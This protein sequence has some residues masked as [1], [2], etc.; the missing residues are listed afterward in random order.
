MPKVKIP[1][2]DW[3]KIRFRIGIYLLFINIP[4]G[5]LGIPLGVFVGAHFGKAHGLQAGIVW[6]I[7]S[8]VMM[9]VGGVLAGENGRQYT[10]HYWTRFRLNILR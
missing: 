4:L 1:H 7:L 9:G 5:Y 10:R 8:W 6:Y 3:K 2:P